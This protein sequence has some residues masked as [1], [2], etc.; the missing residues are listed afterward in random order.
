M[1]VLYRLSTKKYASRNIAERVS[2]SHYISTHENH[3]ELN[4]LGHLWKFIR[5]GCHGEVC[6]AHIV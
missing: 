5:R 2:R 6:G 3:P 4:N 1:D